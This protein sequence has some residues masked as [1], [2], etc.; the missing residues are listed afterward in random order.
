MKSPKTF[1]WRLLG[2]KWAEADEAIKR[3][4]QAHLI[5]LRTDEMVETI[6]KVYRDQKKVS[7]RLREERR[8]NHFAELV[9]YGVPI[10]FPRE[11]ATRE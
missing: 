1:F 6:E 2:F 11:K 4:E 8:K 9:T 3:R 5:K 7:D 10:N